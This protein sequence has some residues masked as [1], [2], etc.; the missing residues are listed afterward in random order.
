MTTPSVRT[1]T[2]S[3]PQDELDEMTNYYGGKRCVVTLMLGSVEWSHTLDANPESSNMRV[4]PYL[5]LSCAMMLK[6]CP[7]AFTNA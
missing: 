2:H 7:L 1:P 4:S 6:M 5:I 3:Y